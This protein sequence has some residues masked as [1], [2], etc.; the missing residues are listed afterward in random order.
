MRPKQ[1]WGTYPKPIVWIQPG[2]RNKILSH[3]AELN[4]WLPGTN[5]STS[6]LQT[7]WT[8]NC[9]WAHPDT[10][11]GLRELRVR[12]SAGGLTL[13]PQTPFSQEN[14]DNL[15]RV[16]ACKDFLGHPPTHETTFRKWLRNAKAHAAA[17]KPSSTTSSVVVVAVVALGHENFTQI[18]LPIRPLE[19]MIRKAVE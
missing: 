3:G 18:S 16:L 2:S 1:G 17:G 4:I 6:Q 9:S 10:R 8:S 19:G 12:G 13:P 7:F 11:G 14:P 15:E 5:Q